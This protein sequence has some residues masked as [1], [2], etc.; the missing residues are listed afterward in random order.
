MA[1]RKAHQE[2]RSAVQCGAETTRP[3]HSKKAFANPGPG[4]GLPL[5]LCVPLLPPAP[6]PAPPGQRSGEAWWGR[7][8]Q[9]LPS[10]T[11]TLKSSCCALSPACLCPP[12]GPPRSPG[13]SRPLRAASFLWLSMAHGL[14]A[15]GALSAELEVGPH[16]PC[17]GGSGGAPVLD[18]GLLWSR[19][20]DMVH[21]EQLTD[22]IPENS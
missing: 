7:P 5:Q 19:C 12:P 8:F 22:A 2:H 14:S 13:P 16:P 11:L 4:G 18:S 10:A 15:C 17:P 21:G 6:S 1:N 9:S 20:P 3:R